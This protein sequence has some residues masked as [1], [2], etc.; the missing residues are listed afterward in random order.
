MFNESKLVHLFL[1][2]HY[3]ESEQVLLVGFIHA[4]RQAGTPAVGNSATSNVGLL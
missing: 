2:Q 4:L 3:R 1:L